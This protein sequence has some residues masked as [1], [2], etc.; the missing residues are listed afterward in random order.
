[1]KLTLKERKLLKEYVRKLV[2]SSPSLNAK[3]GDD[4]A[5][6]VTTADLHK[7]KVAIERIVD[8]LKAKN[9]KESHIFIYL[10][11]VLSSNLPSV[12]YNVKQ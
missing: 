8:K 1:M 12:S 11:W 9:F 2:E 7:Y 3:I 6:M 10:S 5:S 4:I